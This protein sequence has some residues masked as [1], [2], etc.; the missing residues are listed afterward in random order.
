M[1]NSHHASAASARV[2]GNAGSE[3]RTRGHHW[4]LTF[5]LFPRPRV[6][7][8]R[9]QVRYFWAARVGNSCADTNWLAIGHTVSYPY[10]MVTEEEIRRAAVADFRSELGRRGGKAGG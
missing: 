8:C 4:S 1:G 3:P 7:V 10:R 5:P 2:L 6:P 9:V